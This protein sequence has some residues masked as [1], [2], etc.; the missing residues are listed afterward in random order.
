MT[1]IILT[2]AIA[3]I[4]TLSGFSQKKDYVVTIKTKFGDMI[5]ILHDE[6]PKH[7]ANFIK[8]VKEHYYDSLLFHRVISDFMIQGGDPESKSAKAGARLG[9]GGPGYTVPAEFNPKLFH[10]KGALAAAR[11]GDNVNP[12][13]A[14]SGSQFYIVQGKKFSETQL[15]LDQQK[16]NVALL[17]FRQQPENKIHADSLN[18]YNNANSTA[19]LDAY[20]KKIIPIIE[21]QQQV[22]LEKESPPA[23]E[24]IEA[25]A[26]VG[27]TPHLDGQYTVFGKIIQGLDVIDKI[28]AVAKDGSNR[29]VE[30]VRMMM[31]VEELSKK[32]IEKR[33][34]FKY[35]ED[36]PK[37]KR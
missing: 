33:Y 3:V 6:T 13:K 15:R 31:T 29:P 5:A 2:V 16:L 23:P 37:K 8:L 18:A 20:I 27:G 28:A 30:D 14:S 9:N 21:E 11:L 35:P 12:E 34:G 19:R 32:K 22:K 25:Y 26:T 1:R 24:V 17:K 10:Q 7:N 36:K 4:V